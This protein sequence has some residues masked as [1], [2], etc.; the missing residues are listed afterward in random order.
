MKNALE[1]HEGTVC[2]GGRT[3]TNLCFADHIDGLAGEEEELARLVE[4][5]NKPPQPMAQ[6]S[7]LRR[8]SWWQHT[9]HQHRDQSKWTQAWDSHM[10]QVPEVSCY[11]RELHAWGTLQDSTDNSS[12]E[13]LK[14]VWND[15]SISLS[16]KIRLMCSFVTSIFL[17]ACD[18]WILTAELQRRI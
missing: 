15:R 12:I 1:G 10:L 17:Y 5:I 8:P 4:R 9:W 3:I 18:S 7:V 13:R 14:S 2:T 16:S 11:W 6:R